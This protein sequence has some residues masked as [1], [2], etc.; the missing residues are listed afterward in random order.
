MPR[1]GPEHTPPVRVSPRTT[2]SGH[3]GCDNPGV[4]GSQGDVPLV[5]REREL[6]VLQAALGRA[7][8][9]S[10]GAVL[11]A[12]EAGV[13]KTRLVRALLADAP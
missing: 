13:G 6:T 8:E 11:V 7:A 12:G 5:G 3:D 1:T 10:A 4:A 2:T 9:G